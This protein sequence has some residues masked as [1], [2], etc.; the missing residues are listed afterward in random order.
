MNMM[1]PTYRAHI[2]QCNTVSIAL[3]Q[4][5]NELHEQAKWRA[6]QWQI[7]PVPDD[8]QAETVRVV[9]SATSPPELR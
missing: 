8:W 1:K 7:E 3:M 4:Y 2:E 6:D 5:V 9:V